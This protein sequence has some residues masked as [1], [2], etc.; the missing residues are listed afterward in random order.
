MRALLT[1][2]KKIRQW[3][4]SWAASTD[5]SAFH[6]LMDYRDGVMHRAKTENLDEGE[7]RKMHTAVKA[8]AYFTCD[9]LGL[10]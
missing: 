6:K 5:L 9:A 1:R 7:L 2:L 3:N 8:F 4:S 10:S